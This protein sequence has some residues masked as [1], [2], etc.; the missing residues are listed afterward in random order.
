MFDCPTS[1]LRSEDL[2]C[3]AEILCQPLISIPVHM[4][5]DQKSRIL[6][7]LSLELMPEGFVSY[8]S[9]RVHYLLRKSKSLVLFR[10]RLQSSRHSVTHRLLCRFIL[11]IPVRNNRPCLRICCCCIAVRS[12]YRSKVGC[13]HQH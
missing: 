10:G 9:I 2:G 13:A 1:S 3:K 11:R 6:S 5:F 4:Y 8:A 12:D 7:G